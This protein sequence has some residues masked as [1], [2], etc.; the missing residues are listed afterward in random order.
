MIII[1]NLSKRFGEKVVL[2]NFSYQFPKQASIALV[3]A[4][5]VGKS[6]FLNMITGQ[7]ECDGGRVIVPNDCVLAYLPQAPCPTPKAT[8]LAECISGNHGIELL[9]AQLEQAIGKMQEA[10]SDAV[11]EQYEKT[12]L[13]FS[14][15]GG[16]ALEA[17]A[18]GIL[19]GLGF[20]NEKFEAS[21][22]TL[23]G[24]WRMRLEL[25]KLLINDPNFLLLDE[26]T[27]HL[28]LPSLMWL[29]QY[30]RSF[31]GTLLFVSHDR[32][33]LN[34]LSDRTLHMVKGHIRAYNGDFDAFLQQKEERA[35]QAKREQTTLQRK[36]QHMQSFVDR[37]RYKATK[38]KQA[39]SR[40]KM[41]AR[42]KQLESALDIE[43]ATPTTVFKLTV[44]RPSS[45]TVLTLRGCAI[46]YGST[47]LN[48]GLD[49]HIARGQKI[50]VI[51]ANG[52]GKTTLLRSIVGE[53]PW[54]GG[55][56][57]WGSNIDLGYYAQDQL[58][59]LDPE[60]DV[61]T[62]V[63]RLAP[64]I[65][66]QQARAALGRLLIAQA[67]ASNLVKVLSGGEKSKV[68]LAALLAR[69]P[70]FL[71]L[72]EPTNHLD[73]AS[74]ETLAS[75]L[76]EYEGAVLVVSHNRAFINQFAT[77]LFCMDRTKRAE[78]IDRDQ[79]QKGK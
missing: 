45:K 54:L 58:E 21:P 19:A 68:A 40:I 3:G 70:N 56:S 17:N 72:D 79:D 33:F 29:E 69:R 78:L 1:E 5:G 8:I 61:L 37:F 20:E 66:P 4:N 64:G 23:S 35:K 31:R 49:L 9:Q 28:D 10:Y 47:I 18:K 12:E 2:D 44:A 30:L 52:I 11:F 59:M 15:A 53:L 67:E 26:P 71:V 73:L 39:Q 57:R 24:G 63:R 76:Q 13:A 62:N 41:I 50:A 48:K 25:A 74:V 55:E 60:A 51:G 16:Y 34:N 65:S 46:G 22:L 27:N 43:E 75:A 42:L 6:T 14:E 36:Q 77:H 38:A 7:E 32:D